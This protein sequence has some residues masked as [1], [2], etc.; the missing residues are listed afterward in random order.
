MCAET[1]PNFKVKELDAVLKVRKIHT[2]YL[3]ISSALKEDIAKY[4]VRLVVIKSYSTSAG[5]MSRNI[6]HVFR[7]V[8]PQ[9]VIVGVV[10]NDAFNGAFLT[11]SISKT[12]R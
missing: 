7:D 6:D 9:R 3:G 12:T 11:L 1:H 2:A 5:S 4:P 8:I 10:D